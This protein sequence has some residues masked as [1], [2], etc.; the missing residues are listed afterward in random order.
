MPPIAA[1]F[2]QFSAEYLLA[3][4][5]RLG[6]VLLQ[7]VQ[8]EGGGFARGTEAIETLRSLVATIGARRPEVEIGLAG[9]PVMENDEMRTSQT[10][11]LGATALS[12]VG[13]V[14]V[15]VAGFGGVRHPFLAV[16]TLLVAMAWSFGY[17]TIAVG[18]LNILSVSFAVILIGL[19]I[20][21]GIHFTARYLQYRGGGVG[22]E[23]RAGNPF[24]GI[25]HG[26]RLLLHRFHA[27][28]RDRGTGSR[29]RRWDSA[30]LP[31]RTRRPAGAGSPGRCP[32]RAR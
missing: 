26:S 14:C 6:F 13:V 20:D 3:D 7:L 18:H 10:D 27:V 29:C 11:M 17:I 22:C 1:T 21:F 32:A 15:F 12:L 9:L 31:G 5:G 24:R 4:E 28:H 19:G 23:R 8:D 30:L 25:D 2:S 16:I